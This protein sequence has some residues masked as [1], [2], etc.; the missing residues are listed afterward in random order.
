MIV[1]DITSNHYKELIK[2]LGKQFIKA[3]IDNPYDFID[4]ANKGLNANTIKNFG[5]YYDLSIDETAEMLCVSEPT[6][7][8]WTKANINLERNYSVKLF[9]ITDLFL[10]GTEIFETKETFFKWLKLPNTAFGGMFPLELV[11]IPGGISKI[12]DVLGRIAYGVYS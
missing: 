11:S 1:K 10:Y 4:I 3:K 6:I 12:K 2:I 9:E 5:A 7:Y 8:R